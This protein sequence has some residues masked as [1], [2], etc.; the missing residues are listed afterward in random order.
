[1]TFHLDHPDA[2][3]CSLG[4]RRSPSR[5][6]QSTDTVWSMRYGTF[7]NQAPTGQQATLL[8]SLRSAC[9]TLIVERLGVIE[10]GQNSDLL[11]I[12]R[13]WLLRIPKYTQGA[14]ALATEVRILRDLQGRATLHGIPRD[15]IADGRA[16]RVVPVGPGC[17]GGAGADPRRFRP[18]Q[19]P[20]R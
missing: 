5:V 9:P 6:R 10:G 1:M 20:L 12:N 15:T 3:R 18:E 17:G 14:T 4:Q 19:H 8:H 2:D 16:L 7:E 13:E 11:L